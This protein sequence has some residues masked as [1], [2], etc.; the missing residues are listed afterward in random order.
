MYAIIPGVCQAL[1]RKSFTF[2]AEFYSSD[3]CNLGQTQHLGE[4]RTYL[5]CLCVYAVSATDDQV[6]GFVLQGKGEG[7]RRSQ[8]IRTGERWVYQVHSPVRPHRQALNESL[9]RLGRPHGVGHD[10]TTQGFL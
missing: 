5:R 10:L 6:V 8:G 2:I 7:P 4:L 3:G 1:G 9:S